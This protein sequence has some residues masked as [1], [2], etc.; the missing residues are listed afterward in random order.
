MLLP[1]QQLVKREE[2]RGRRPSAES[3]N[4]LPKNIKCLGHKD[5]VRGRTQPD[6]GAPEMA[7]SRTPC[8]S[9]DT[10]P[11]SSLLSATHPSPPIQAPVYPTAPGSTSP[12]VCKA[13]VTRSLSP[14]QHHS[15]STLSL[16]PLA[17]WG[18]EHWGSP[19]DPYPA[20]PPQPT[21]RGCFL[22]PVHRQHVPG[23]SR[24]P[25]TPQQTLRDRLCLGLWQSLPHQPH[26]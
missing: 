17:P 1:A 3:G 8:P 10:V 12:L 26:Q 11:A 20:L 9:Q 23:P 16:A 22:L 14:T 18:Q 15:S 7:S 6:R 19:W 21:G 24:N 5:T 13:K 25:H 4:A 2:G